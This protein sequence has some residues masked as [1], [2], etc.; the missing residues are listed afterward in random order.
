MKPRIRRFLSHG[1]RLRDK[2]Y[3]RRQLSVC[4]SRNW[5]AALGDKP[6]P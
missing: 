6:S 4:G 2:R 5:R 3:I 1:R